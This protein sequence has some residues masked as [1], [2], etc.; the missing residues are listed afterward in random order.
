MLGEICGKISN[1][2]YTNSTK[3]IWG[4]CRN[5]MERTI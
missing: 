1:V 3:L 5:G 4:K 2:C